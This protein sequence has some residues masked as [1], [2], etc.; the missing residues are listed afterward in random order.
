MFFTTQS[1]FTLTVFF[2][3][4]L[5]IARAQSL[6]GK[7]VRIAD[8]D[9][10]TLLD[11]SNTQIKVRLYWIDS[12]EKGQN[13]SNV[14]KQFTSDLCFSKNVTIDVKDIDEYRSTMGVN[15]TKINGQGKWWNAIKAAVGT[16]LTEIIVTGLYE[17]VKTKLGFD[18]KPKTGPQPT[19]SFGQMMYVRIP[20]ST[21]SLE[22]SADSITVD[23]IYNLKFKMVQGQGPVE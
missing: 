22:F 5:F 3:F 9:T 17:A 13:F 6:I 16:S 23:G 10:I 1:K 19:I 2:F 20:G 12:T 15:W 18:D 11:S 7:I 21:Y 14:G 8:G 4:R